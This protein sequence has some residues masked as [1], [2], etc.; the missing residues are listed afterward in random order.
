MK[1]KLFFICIYLLSGSLLFAQASLASE[2][3][4]DD[5]TVK[6]AAG[7]SVSYTLVRDAIQ[8][9][10]WYY[11]PTQSRL[12]EI[13]TANG[14]SEPEFTLLKYQYNNPQKPGELLEGGIIQFAIVLSPDNVSLTQ[15]KNILIN[16]TRKPGIRLAALP[17][18]QA[19]VKLVTPKG[20]FLA[21]GSETEGIAPLLA[22][23]KMVFS[24]TLSKIGT[25]IYDALVNSNTGMG[26][27]VNF[28]YNGLTP[29]AGF[30]IVVDWDESYKFFSKNE[31]SRAKVGGMYSWFSGSAEYKKEKQQIVQE[32]KENKCIKIEAVTGENFSDSMLYAYIDPI[33][34]KITEELFNT[35]AFN[36]RMDSMLVASSLAPD[37]SGP[38]RDS[39]G[40]LLNFLNVSVGKSIAIK[41]IQMTKK[42]RQ[43]FNFNIKQLVERKSLAGGFVGLGRYPQAVKDKLAIL[44]AGGKWESAYFILPPIADDDD[45]GIKKIGLE[46]K[47]SNKGKYY[48]GQVFNWTKTE[49]WTDRNGTKRTVAAFPLIELAKEDPE[50]K[51]K[52]FELKMSINSGNDEFTVVQ[53]IPA[54][55]TEKNVALPM[56]IVD[57]VKIDPDLLSFRRMIPESQL[58]YVS[59][60]LSDGTRTKRATILPRS[61]NGI[62]VAPR[63][64]YWMLEKAGNGKPVTAQIQ[65]VLKNGTRVNWKGNGKNLTDPGMSYEIILQDADYQENN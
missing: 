62:A 14:V 32:L 19:S 50:M 49:G 11:I 20:E 52:A 57:M 41:D 26:V 38:R 10:Q 60:T 1:K 9:E 7:E 51:D 25:D 31:V 12:Y 13:K 34:K 28:T 44:I 59:V 29:P 16:R 33:L 17:M 47:L 48:S 35:S 36:Q 15:L 46:I 43:E 61:L 6:T 58:D 54:G 3:I 42:G 53:Q 18:K 39:K 55:N 5:I 2:D 27:V 22:S 23:Q 30:K 4:M 63:P 8:K 64:V 65:F 21:E 37:T 24:L 56:S 45:I 40:S